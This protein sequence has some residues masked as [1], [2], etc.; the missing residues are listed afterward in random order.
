[1]KVTPPDDA[2]EMEA[3]RVT[4]QVMRMLGPTTTPQHRSPDGVQRMCAACAEDT[5]EKAVHRKRID[6]EDEIH[7][8]LAGLSPAIGNQLAERIRGLTGSHELPASER[9]FFEPRFG[10]DFSGVRVYSSESAAR[11]AG[12]LNARAFTRGRDIVFGAGQYAP[13]TATGRRLIAHELAHVVQQG[14]APDTPVQRDLATPEPTKKPPAQP[15]LTSSQIDEAIRFNRSL[16]DKTRTEQ[17]QDLIGT[18]M[19]GT[20]SAVDILAVADIQERYG[21]HKDGKVDPHTFDFLDKETRLEKLPKV[22]DE[23]LLAFSVAVDA[24]TIG[25]VVAGYRTISGHFVMKAQF[26][27]YCG[28]AHYVYRQ[29]VCG[30]WK[31]IRG[32]VTTDLGGTFTYL[33]G[34]LTTAFKEDANTTTRALNYGHR[35]QANEGTN[36]GYFDDPG[37]TRANQARGCHYIGDDTPGGPDAVMSGDVFDIRVAFRGDIQRRRKVVET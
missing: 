20:W 33:P 35:G 28:C 5:D 25:P 16:Y 32:G 36:N 4:D 13:G 23:C 22:D 14:R 17:I 37:G 3:D 34:G 10:H 31:R 30:H 15:A 26:S 1:L 24:P 19:T 27:K 6:Q 7:G 8:K 21:L 29:F 2:T 12:E 18:R 11:V 9:A